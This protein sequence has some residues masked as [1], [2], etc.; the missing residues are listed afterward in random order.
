VSIGEREVAASYTQC[1]FID[2][3]IDVQ[4]QRALFL[5]ARQ[6]GL[7]G[8][9]ALSMWGA[10]KSAALAGIYQENQKVPAL[11]AIANGTAWWQL[12]PA[13]RDSIVFE[14][15][16]VPIMVFRRGIAND[17]RRVAA[18]LLFAWRESSVGALPMII[19]PPSGRPCLPAPKPSPPPPPAPEPIPSGVEPAPSSS[20]PPEPACSIA[21]KG[22][23]GRFIHTR[24]LPVSGVGINAT[25]SSDLSASVASQPP[26]G[27]CRVFVS[28]N[29]DTAMAGKV[30]G[31]GSFQ[32]VVN[33]TTGGRLALTRRSP[34][35]HTPTTIPIGE[36]DA[37]LPGSGVTS[38]QVKITTGYVFSPPGGAT[39]VSAEDVLTL[40]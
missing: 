32:L 1:D 12:I 22:A 34:S 9:D 19:P 7:D 4:A 35:I 8:N 25:F 18:A 33:G 3:R 14:R 20:P 13:G 2:A 6:G 28:A 29:I 39:T 21:A 36:G 16:A 23:S 31:F 11:A 38:L 40:L 5:L 37:I 30:R 17:V 26:S 10:V 27:E 24:F 15:P